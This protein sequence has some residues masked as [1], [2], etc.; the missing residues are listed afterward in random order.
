MKYSKNI[1][2]LLV[3]FTLCVAATVLIHE[4]TNDFDLTLTRY[5][6]GTGHMW[7]GNWPGLKHYPWPILYR[8]APWPA[9][10]VGVSALL[11]LLA[12]WFRPRLRTLRRPALFL[13]LLL[14]LGP[15][16]LINVIFKDNYGR[17]RPKELQEYGGNLS[18]SHVWEFGNGGRNSSFP[19]GHAG[20]AFYLMAPWFLYRR[21]NRPQ[22]IFFLLVGL[23]WGGLVGTARMLQGGHYLTDVLWAAGMV[24]LTGEVLAQVLRLDGGDEHTCR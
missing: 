1:L 6:A 22:A 17:V 2:A 19:S 23:G 15:G 11:I 9:I 8:L 5:I 4:V 12:G 7:P 3:P 18:Y 21:N 24:Y 16:L 20:I 13:V 10:L 14:A